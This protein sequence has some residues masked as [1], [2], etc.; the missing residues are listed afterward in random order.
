VVDV[1]LETYYDGGA[2]G[3]REYGYTV[4]DLDCD[5]SVQGS[6]FGLGP[7]PGAP[8]APRPTAASTRAADLAR[9]NRQEQ[10]E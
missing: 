6:A 8:E 5:H 4:T 3:A 10:P 9:A 1:H 2:G 7:A